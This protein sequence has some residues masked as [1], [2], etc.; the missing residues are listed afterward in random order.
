M[1]APSPLLRRDVVEALRRGTVPRRGLD[2]FAV[3]TDRLERALQEEL[4][5]CAAGGSVF[6]ALRGDFGCGK[7]FT[8]RWYQQQAMARGFAVAEVQI[9]END[10]PLH[11]LETVYRRAM[12]GLRTAEW[13]T[14]AFRAVIS[15]W[16][17]GLEEE[18][19]KQLRD[20]DDLDALGRGVGDLMEAR[21][22]EVSAVQPQYAAVLRAYHA[23][24]LHDDH[25]VAEGLIAWLMGQPNVSADI[26]RRAGIKGDVD[27]TG[28]LG[29]FRGLLA[30]LQQ[31]GRP[32]LLLVLDEVETIQRVRSDSR[33]KSL[34]ALRKLIDD[35]YGGRFAGLYVLI[36]GTPA[37]FDGPNGVRRLPP[38][39]Q[40]LHVDFS[41]DARWDNPRDVQVRLHAFDLDRLVE[42]GRRVRELYPTEAPERM[43]ARVTDDVLAGLAKS[44]AGRLGGKVGVAPRIFLR[45]L[46]AGLLDRVDLYPE[47]DPHRDFELSLTA[48]ELTVEERAAA[49]GGS[50]DDFDLEL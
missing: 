18:V 10:T 4:D 3:G 49:G 20:P 37:F 45:K 28:A 11:R 2:L 17:M 48:D 40:R 22:A 46:V 41:G 25:A 19:T 44:V 15:Q 9:S 29:F 34:E 26:K 31:C 42:V 12:E 47:F 38:L 24:Q 23:A 13:D 16:I 8:A 33:D 30:V 7:S 36:T 43:A 14:G 5:R 27:H 6:K 32:G 21:L 50:P 39:A 35:L 1:S